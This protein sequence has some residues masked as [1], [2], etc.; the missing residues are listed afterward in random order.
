MN[1]K[2]IVQSGMIP[3]RQM[4][5]AQLMYQAITGQYKFN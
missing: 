2:E 3:M 1:W 5:G 4:A